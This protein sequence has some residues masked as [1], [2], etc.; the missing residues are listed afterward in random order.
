MRDTGKTDLYHHDLAG[1]AHAVTL[2]TI[3]LELV[4]TNVEHGTQRAVDEAHKVLEH[5]KVFGVEGRIKHVMIPGMIEEEDDRPVEMKP[6]LDVLDFWSAIQPE[7]PGVS[8]LCTQVNSF[9]D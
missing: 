1:G 8:G 6:K 7:L 9:M 5:S 2:N 4:P 3:A